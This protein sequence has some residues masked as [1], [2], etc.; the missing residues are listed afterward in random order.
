[1]TE[2]RKNLGAI[3]KHQRHNVNLTLQQLSLTS[4]V[5]PSHLGRI[6]KGERF[7]SASVLRRIAEPLN[8][9][10]DELFTL[11]GFLSTQ[12]GSPRQKDHLKKNSKIDPYVVEMLSREP[13]EIQKA[14]IDILAVLKRL[15]NLDTMAKNLKELALR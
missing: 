9:R 13:V 11:A 12:I 6:E 5:S 2:N 14:V 4:G 15:R 8:F 1:M 10:E 3:I 7:P